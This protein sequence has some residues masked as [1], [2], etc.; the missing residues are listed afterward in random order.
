MGRQPWIIYGIMRT[1][2]AVTPVPGMVYHLYLFLGL[3]LALAAATVWLF[4]R[5]IQ[6]VQRK[7]EAPAASAGGRR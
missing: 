4:K 2:D 7:F 3:Y 5:Q 6:A 1:K